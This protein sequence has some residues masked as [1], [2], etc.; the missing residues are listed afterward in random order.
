MKIDSKKVGKFISELRKNNKMTQEKLSESLLVDRGTISKWE[1]GVYIPNPDD[2]FCLSQI[3]DVTVNELLIG[4]KETKSNK[5]DINNVTVDILKK[6]KK[7]KR[8]LIYN[9]VILIICLLSF[10]LYY[11]LNNYNSIS[12]YKITG[13]SDNFFVASGLFIISPEKSYIEIGSIDNLHNN[14][15]DKMTLYYEKNNE[16]Y[17]ICENDDKIG[18]LKNEFNYNE[19]F[20]YADIKYLMS[21]LRLEIE[22]NDSKSKEVIEL[23]LIKD[24]SNDYIFFDSKNS[25]SSDNKYLEYNYKIPKY[26]KDNF[27]LDESNRKYYLNSKN[28][29]TI[30]YQ[31]YYFDADVY[32]V[33]ELH[34][35]YSENFTFYNET[36][37][38]I[39]VK[40]KD[41][42]EYDNFNYN[43]VDEKCID[44][45]C[46]S[47]LVEYFSK[48]Y[49]SRIIFE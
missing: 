11:F 45:E 49:L 14:I 34:E 15:V 42:K 20:S 5:T 22:Y 29:K 44:G 47:K 41:D 38:V 33:D 6:N 24:F 23:K 12:I 19:L 40:Y 18:L 4:E 1:R 21:N 39:Y 28:G 35:G 16:K 26:V 17:I 30:I 27:K 7:I 46:N 9:I 36:K 48:N 3:F 37:D 43:L 25:I 8:I 32:V 10:F 13:E 2:L 31:S